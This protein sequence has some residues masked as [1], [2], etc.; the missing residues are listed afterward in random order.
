MLNF[1]LFQAG[2]CKHCQRMTLQNGHLKIVNY[3]SLCA[4]IQHPNHGNILYDTG[5]SEHFDVASKRFPE[6]LY[7]WITPVHQTQ[8]LKNQL[9]EKNIPAE[10]ITYIV[11]S[12][13]HSDHISALKDF[14]NAKF[15]CH[16]D[17]WKSIENVGRYRGLLK[18]FMPD[19]LPENFTKRLILLD[20]KNSSD[21]PQTL[22]PFQQGFD[23]FE[24][25]KIFAIELPGHAAG[26]IGLYFRNN[27]QQEVFL[28]GDS[29]WHRRSFKQCCY[30][31]R[32]THFIFDNASEYRHTI[33]KLHHLYK[34]N[35]TIKLIPS[36]CTETA[37][38]FG[39]EPSC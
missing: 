21:A 31:S 11:I 1:Q 6:R 38:T 5:Y 15:I 32:L 2:F 34:N 10:T 26:H 30:P 7:Q 14:P 9:A 36:H 3:P 17:A 4:L 8:S 37:K 22:S 16:L 18:A 29:C 35:L 28:I 24:D 20:R 33:E 39:I 19:L 23:V 12:H 13:F 25:K 27:N